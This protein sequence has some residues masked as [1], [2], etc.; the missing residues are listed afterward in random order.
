MLSIAGARHHGI[1]RTGEWCIWADFSFWRGSGEVSA[2]TTTAKWRAGW[3]DLLIRLM[4]PPTLRGRFPDWPQLK[5]R[6][7]L[8]VM[9]CSCCSCDFFFWKV[10]LYTRLQFYGNRTPEEISQYWQFQRQNSFQEKSFLSP[11]VHPE[12]AWSIRVWFSSFSVERRWV[13][14]AHGVS[15]SECVNTSSQGESAC[16]GVSLSEGLPVRICM[17]PIHSQFHTKWDLSTPNFTPGTLQRENLLTP[18]DVVLL[19]TREI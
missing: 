10:G 7:V 2:K 3:I 13:W 6:S 16:S 4:V 14:G 17:K 12:L 11:V 19:K 8:V 18:R 1:L 15:F 5:T 9:N